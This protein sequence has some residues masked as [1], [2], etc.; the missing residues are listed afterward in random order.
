[1]IGIYVHSIVR[2]EREAAGKL[3]FLG[4]SQNTP[5]HFDLRFASAKDQIRDPGRDQVCRDSRKIWRRLRAA[6]NGINVGQIICGSDLC[7]GK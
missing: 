3:V 6:A 4:T 5:R 7:V 1:M 2:D